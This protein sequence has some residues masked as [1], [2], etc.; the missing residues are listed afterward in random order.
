MK[1]KKR[2]SRPSRP[3]RPLN[4][5]AFRTRVAAAIDAAAARWQKEGKKHEW[6]WHDKDAADLRKVARLIRKDQ[7]ARAGDVAGYMDTIVRDELPK[8]FF[9]LL[10]K[11]GVLW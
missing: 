7:V 9:T 5:K 10:D 4:D 11:H 8:G 1:P 2:G 3:S 6:P